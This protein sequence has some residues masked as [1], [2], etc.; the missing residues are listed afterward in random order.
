[1]T[2]RHLSLVREV[3]KA[4]R[5]SSTFRPRGP[6]T[7]TLVGAIAKARV[8]SRL[9][10]AEWPALRRAVKWG[11][12]GEYDSARQRWPITLAGELV[13]AAYNAG[14]AIGRR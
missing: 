14:V 11:L 12:L 10:G 1:M 13:L 2:D 4:A 6:I 5:R 9:R 8:G 7:P 3:R